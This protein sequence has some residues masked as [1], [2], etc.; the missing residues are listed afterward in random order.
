MCLCVY[1]CCVW[2]CLYCAVHEDLCVWS[3][4]SFFF[5][6]VCYNISIRSE[7]S[8]G[9]LYLY[10]LMLMSTKKW[11][12]NIVEKTDNIM[13]ATFF[14]N[15]FWRVLAC[16][17]SITCSAYSLA[18]VLY[19]GPL[20]LVRTLVFCRF[21]LSLTFFFS[22]Y[23]FPFCSVLLFFLLFC[24]KP[25]DLQEMRGT[26]EIIRTKYNTNTAWKCVHFPRHSLD[27]LW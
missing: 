11:K 3:F 4:C 18:H 13:D 25:F 14:F 27:A 26:V 12:K 2:V 24:I 19:V 9:F 1:V 23:I 20:V 15:L 17:V 7:K 8:K 16:H 10:L 6:C 21:V 22:I 5:P